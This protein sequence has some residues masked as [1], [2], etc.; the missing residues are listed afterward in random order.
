[1]QITPFSN[2]QK[3]EWDNF[4]RKESRNGGIFHERHFLDYHPLGRFND[5]S[6][7]IHSR[8]KVVGVFPAAYLQTEQGLK[9]ASHPGS[10]GG[11][12]IYHR[13]HGLRQVLEMLELILLYYRESGVA[14]LEVRLAEPIFSELSDGE[15]TYLLWHRGFRLATR[16]ISSCVSLQDFSWREFERKKNENDIRRLRKLGLKIA[17][18]EE[19][20]RIYPLIEKNLDNRHAK[21]PTHELAE[22]EELKQRY[23]DRLHFW[24]AI[25][26]D[27]PIATIVTFAVNNTSV[28]VFY[29]AMDYTHA[30]LQVMPLL[31]HDVFEYYQ[32]IGFKWFNFGIS[33]RGDWIKWGILEFKERMGGRATTRETWIYDDLAS[34]VAYD[35]SS[36]NQFNQVRT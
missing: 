26:D 23:P 3:S 32:V 31:F 34:Y 17:L 2:I 33:S 10:S 27:M 21:R 1:M 14:S 35:F 25:L 13:K 12:L 29:I 20:A 30:N 7:V 8:N 6:L 4:V 9:V 16:E 5:A 22:L 11:G 18:F 36:V 19:A 15:L 28:H 24:A